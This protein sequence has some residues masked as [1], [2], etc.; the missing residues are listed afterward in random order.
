MGWRKV[1]RHTYLARIFHE[2]NIPGSSYKFIV[3]LDTSQ[4]EPDPGG[5]DQ[6][7]PFFLMCWVDVGA[8]VACPIHSCGLGVSHVGDI[9]DMA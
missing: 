6:I 2:G 5:I 4:D 7:E 3:D 9:V 8:D 1:S